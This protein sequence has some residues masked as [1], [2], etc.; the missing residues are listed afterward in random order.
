MIDELIDL[1]EQL[2]YTRTAKDEIIDFHI[3]RIK[4]H[5]AQSKAY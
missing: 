2:L 1:A 3:I 4:E 5:L